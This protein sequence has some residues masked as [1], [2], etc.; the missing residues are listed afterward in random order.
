[1]YARVSEKSTW[2]GR[3]HL[4]NQH[5]ETSRSQGT[6]PI[7][8]QHGAGVTLSLVLSSEVLVLEVAL[9]PV[10]AKRRVT[11]ESHCSGPG[12]GTGGRA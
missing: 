8:R 7:T 2:E 6:H 1:M 4:L 3:W 9:S 12:G 10:A 5:Q 11:A